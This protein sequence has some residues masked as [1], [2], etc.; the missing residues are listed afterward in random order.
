PFQPAGLTGRQGRSTWEPKAPRG[1]RL[2]CARRGGHRKLV[3]VVLMGKPIQRL[4]V[5]VLLV[6][7]LSQALLFAAQNAGNFAERALL[8]PDPEATAALGLSWAGFC[9]FSAFTVNAVGVC[10]LVVGRRTGGDPLGAPAAARQALL[11]AG[12]GGLLG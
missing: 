6:Q 3:E 10:Q 11:L 12:C 8:A 2:R 5:Q 9:L 4:S 1:Q 7:M